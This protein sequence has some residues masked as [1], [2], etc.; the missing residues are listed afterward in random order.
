MGERGAQKKPEGTL[1]PVEG[2]ERSEGL[3]QKGCCGFTT[4][5]GVD[6]VHPRVPIDLSDECLGRKLMLL[7]EVEMAGDMARECPLF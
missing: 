4:G 6:G 3:A 7:L 5:V 2:E 1:A